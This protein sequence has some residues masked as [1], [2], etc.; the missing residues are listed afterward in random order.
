M[1]I[2][3]ISELSIEELKKVFDKNEKLRYDVKN[4]MV[5]NEMFWIEEQMDYLRDSLSS[6]SIGQ[7]NRNQHITVK[8]PSDFIYN[9]A[10]LQKSVPVLPIE[11][12]DYIK[13]AID[14]VEK[15]RSVDMY[16]N[17]YD[18]LEERIEKI[19]NELADAV[20]NQY[21]KILDDYCLD[22]KYAKEHFI[23]FY[24]DNRM[25]DTFYINDDYELFESVSYVKSY[26]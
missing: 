20:K 24:V 15:Y 26:A 6:W 2:K 23:E 12:D 3:H 22:D 18:E 10:E 7:C 11:Y 1:S 21:T 9:L 4:D 8:N 19:A 25:D 17:E 14:L 5:K 16:S 13:E